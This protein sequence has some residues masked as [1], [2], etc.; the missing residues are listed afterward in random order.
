MIRWIKSHQEYTDFMQ[1]DHACRTAHFYAPILSSP[2]GLAVGI[3]ISKKVGSAVLRNKLKRR[4]KAWCRTNSSCMPPEH[5]MNLIAR[6]GAA[7][8]SWA[9]LSEELH[10]LMDGVL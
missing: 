5:K 10:A 6:R 3:T 9:E 7:Q 4:I 2:E 8:L 1:A